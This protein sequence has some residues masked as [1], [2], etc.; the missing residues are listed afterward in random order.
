MAAQ[1]SV[2]IK[3]IYVQP[4]TGIDS[5]S[6][7]N[8]LEVMF[9]MNNQADASVLHLQFGT[10]QDLGDVLTI[11]ASIIEQGGKY[12]VSYGG[13]EQ[14]IVGYDTSLSVELT[15]S[16]ESAYSYITLYIG[17]INGESSNKLYFIK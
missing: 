8:Q 12:Y 2:Q 1:S 17:D 11:D 13:V 3:D 10:A 14:L 5:T 16:Q 7:N 6:M 15:Q 9:K 4:I